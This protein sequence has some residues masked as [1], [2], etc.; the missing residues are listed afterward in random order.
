M[1]VLTKK[2]SSYITR[3][4]IIADQ[5]S[6]ESVWLDRLEHTS[7][8]KIKSCKTTQELRMRMKYARKLSIFIMYRSPANI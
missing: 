6:I 5:S 4:S 1:S 3:F 7:V 2:S 8:C